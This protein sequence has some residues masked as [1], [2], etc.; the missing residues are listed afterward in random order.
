MHAIRITTHKLTQITNTFAWFD[1]DLP[2]LSFLFFCNFT[3]LNLTFF[4]FSPINLQNVGI[5]S[6][7]YL[8]RHEIFPI[9]GR[10]QIFSFQILISKVVGFHLKVTKALFWAG[11]LGGFRLFMACF[12]FFHAELSL[13]PAFCTQ[14]GMQ[15]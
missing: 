9:F 5:C 4:S 10:F 15:F 2:P 6:N 11:G 1:T 12:R 3:C 13:M 7:Y 8:F 14:S